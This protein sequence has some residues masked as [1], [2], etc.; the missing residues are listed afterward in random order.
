M[1]T[2]GWK[3]FFSTSVGKKQIVGLTGLGISLFTLTHMAGNL[4]LFVGPEAYNSYS[5]HLVTNPLLPVA[6]IGLVVMFLAHIFYTVQL[7]A[8]NRAARGMGNYQRPSNPLKGGSIAV[9]TAILSG[10]LLL[11]FVILHLITFKWGTYYSV[12]YGNV[13]M[14]D[15]YRL[16]SE[17]FHEPGYV[18]WYE[19]CLLLL[20]LHLSHGFS[21][22]FQ[23]L[24][25]SSVRRCAVKKLGYAF[26]VIVAGGF[27]AQPLFFILGGGK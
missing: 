2:A 1:R 5:Y 23:S 22:T 4:L 18:A 17:K 7:T 16:V 20:G 6:E 3:R 9:R 24:G 21:A 19:F 8:A 27:I 12:T 10:L 13:E 11:A 25:V 15:L 14:R 26:A